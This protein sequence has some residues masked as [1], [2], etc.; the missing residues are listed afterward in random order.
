V[1]AQENILR[2]LPLSVDVSGPKFVFAHIMAPHPPYLF[3][4]DGTIETDSD[5]YREALG[6][7]ATQELFIE[8]YKRQVIFVEDQILNIVKEIINNSENDPIII[9]QG[10]HGIDGS[11]RM[12]ILNA[13]YVPKEVESQLF[14]TITPVNTFRVIFN[15][16][17]ATDY[18]L[19]PDESWYS[20]Y[21]DWF[22]IELVDENNPACLVK[23]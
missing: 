19:L 9:I 2:N 14:S 6:Q 5:F 20:V 10:D 15:G 21:P 8:G 17:F 13:Y 18:E 1:E 23:K 11:N 4:E 22:E 12:D 3:R 7:P 16:V